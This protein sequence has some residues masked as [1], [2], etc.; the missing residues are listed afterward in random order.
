MPRHSDSS[1]ILIARVESDRA[2]LAMSYLE[3][4]IN[5]KQDAEEVIRRHDS[6]GLP[7][8]DFYPHPDD[9]EIDLYTGEV[10]IDGPMTEDQAGAQEVVRKISLKKLMRFFEVQS[11]LVEDPAN[12]ALK[13]EMRDLQ[14]Y[15]DFF[16]WSSQRRVRLEA[17]RRSREALEAQKTKPKKGK[18]EDKA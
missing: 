8:P 10:V 16:E 1:W 4:A 17:L 9:L 11:A 12:D 6:E 15:K 2:A 13:T 5:Y 7:P 18:K 14:K 3:A